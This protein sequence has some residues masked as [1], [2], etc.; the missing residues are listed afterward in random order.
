MPNTLQVGSAVDENIYSSYEIEPGSRTT[1]ASSLRHCLACDRYG[2]TALNCPA[3]R[4]AAII[5][6]YGIY[7]DIVQYAAVKTDASVILGSD[8]PINMDEPIDEAPENAP[9]FSSFACI[10]EPT[11]ADEEDPPQSCKQ[12]KRRKKV[13]NNNNVGRENIIGTAN[14]IHESIENAN[15]VGM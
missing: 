11:L 6:N 15:L 7:K 4:T 12:R 2:H 14:S 5:A 8:V 13:G 1:S 10:I 3:P 9:T